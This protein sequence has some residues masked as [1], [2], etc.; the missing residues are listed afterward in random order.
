MMIQMELEQTV[1][2][3]G[4]GTVLFMV[5]GVVLMLLALLIILIQMKRRK[6]D[7]ESDA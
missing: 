7:S 5:A 3:G 1:E 4:Q 6:R 2:T